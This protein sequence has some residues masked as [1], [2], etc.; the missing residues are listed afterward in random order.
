MDKNELKRVLHEQFAPIAEAVQRKLAYLQSEDVFT[1]NPYPFESDGDSNNDDSALMSA[2]GGTSNIAPS[3]PA[4]SS[5]TPRTIS[6]PSAGNSEPAAPAQPQ[7]MAARIAALR[8]ISMPGDYLSH[9]KK[10]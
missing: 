6:I 5:A 7:N 4:P 8:G 3:T 2:F 9:R 10:N 1:D